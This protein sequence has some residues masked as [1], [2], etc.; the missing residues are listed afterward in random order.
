MKRMSLAYCVLLG[1]ILAWVAPAAAQGGLPDEPIT[2]DNA[3]RLIPDAATIPQ[4]V[5]EAAIHGTALSP[6]GQTVA[7]GYSDGYVRLWDVNS[8]DLQLELPTEAAFVPSVAFSPDGALL[9]TGAGFAEDA[10]DYRVTVWDAVTG[11]LERIIST[12][13]DP[14][15]SLAFSADG[16]LLAAGGGDP[17]VGPGGYQ[18][19]DVEQGRRVAVGYPLGHARAGSEPVSVYALAFNPRSGML[20]AVAGDGTVRL[21]DPRIG[22]G[23]ELALLPTGDH[24]YTADLAFSPDGQV[25]AGAG[26]TSTCG[27]NRACRPTD[28]EGGVLLWR[29]AS[30]EL[31]G[32]LA[33]L[34]GPVWDV[35]FSPDGQLLASVG[36][37]GLWLWDTA[38]WTPVIH[39][40]RPQ[41]ELLSVAFSPDGTAVITVGENTTI[42]VWRVQPG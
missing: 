7:I 11:A 21:F 39:F 22:F 30:H 40:E 35:A 15:F 29:M 42:Q 28:E 38:D 18:V 34:T 37:S 41:G 20:A 31:A 33:G 3:V 8:G 12:F 9:A 1:L 23:A 4:S 32:R 5:P 2:P 16:H 14:I 36:Y 13:S 19:W 10:L 25:L 17:W 6:D 26:T 24:W 27:W